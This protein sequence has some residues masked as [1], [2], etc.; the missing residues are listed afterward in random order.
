MQ[1]KKLE[2]YALKLESISNV[3]ESLRDKLNRDRG[4]IESLN[5]EIKRNED[6]LFSLEE[7][8]KIIIKA[9]NLLNKISNDLRGSSLVS[10]E[11]IVTSAIKE[12]F[13]DKDVAFRMEM[14]LETAKPSLNTFIKEGERE[15][16]ILDSRG[17]GMAD[18]ISVALRVCIKSM[19]KPRIT[20][21]IILDESF[22]FLHGTSAEGSYPTNAFKFLKKITSGLDE[23]C[24]F[25]TGIETKDFVQVADKVFQIKQENGLST[26]SENE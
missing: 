13:T 26:I 22:K 8:Q 14:N 4:G 15:F 23:Q 3:N 12:V 10:I 16:S 2:Q 11:G 18:L 25:V 5:S 1:S 20:F 24:I 9:Q 19:Y 21:P 7:K 17:L 6:S